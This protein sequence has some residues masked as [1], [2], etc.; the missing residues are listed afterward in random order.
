MHRS[1][2]TLLTLVAFA[3]APLETKAATVLQGAT[4]AYVAFEAEGNP[5]ITNGAPA[6]WITTNDATASGN[7]VLYIAG[8]TDNALAPHS[9][10]LYQI[11]FATAGT[12]HLYYRFK[13]D[14]ARTVADQFTGNS[15]LIPNLLG[16]FATAGATGLVDFHTAASNG[17]QAPANNVFDWQREADTAAYTV[18]A[19]EVAAGLP[20]VLSIG[21]R[22]AGFTVDRWILSPDPALTDA[23]L[24]ALENSETSVVVQGASDAYVAFEAET[25]AR[26]IAGTPAFW[27]TT[28]DVTASASGVLYIAGTTD[29]ALAPHSFALYQ[30]KFATA[31]TYHLYY[32]FKADAARTVADQFTGNSCLIPN[33][34]GTFTTAG[35]A[36]L[37]DFHTA[38]SNGG[39]APANN[40]FDWQREADTA[41]YTVSAA[42][43]AAGVPLVLTIATREAG[44]TVDR[45]VLSPDPA[46][47]D[48][49]LDALPNSGARVAAPSIDKAVG[50]A[51]L[52]TV[53]LSFTRPLAAASVLANRFTV[54]GGLAVTAAVLDVEDPRRVTLTTGAQTQGTVYTVTAVNVTDT[55]GTP[56]G[57]NTTKTFTAWKLVEGWATQ[58]I[59]LGATGSTVADLTGSAAYIAGTPSEIRWVK[60]F[61]LNNDPRGPNLGA[62]I[63]AF[64]TPPAAGIQNFYVFNDDEAELLLSSNQTEASLQSLNVFALSTAPVFDDAI[65]AA[66]PALTAGQRYLLVG[67]VKSGG[68]D[69]RLSVA[70]QP[71]GAGTPAANLSVLGGSRI[72]TFVNPDLGNVKFDQQPANATAA[73]GDRAR[74]SVKV[75]ATEGPVYYQWRVNGTD[76]P[77]ATRTTY[78]T[79][80]LTAADSGK[81]YSVV[82]SVAGKDTASANATLTVQGTTASNLQSYIGINFVGGGDNLPGPLTGVDV[83]GV[84]LQ[85]NWNNLTGTTFDQ[86]A[87]RDAAGA[88]TPITFTA[89]ATDHWY[90]GTLGAGDAN[91]VLLQG[92]LSA[93]ASLDPFALT[94]NNVPA[95]TYNLVVY[96]VGF[97]FQASYEESF[98]VTGATAS[99]TLHVKAE[100]GLE[101]NASPSFRRMTS[102]DANNRGA[103]GNYVQFDN[104]RPAADGSLTIT[105]AWESTNVGNGHQPAV[106]GIQLV[107]VGAAP[108]LPVSLSAALQGANLTISWPA[109]AAGFVLESS[110]AIGAGAAWTTVAGTPNPITVAG[111]TSVSVAAGTRFYRLKK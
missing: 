109:S 89:T 105:A 14:A 43:V 94:L 44:F 23:A 86:V 107:K 87:L 49:T 60:G 93:G 7:S 81:V 52:N 26:L 21:T 68:G 10:A 103:L 19:A 74:F 24:D 72:S 39:Q 92:Y 46:L 56:V 111:S 13:A 40:V 70:S 108:A 58:E 67:R 31:G 27:I 69:F 37:A 75:T 50:S 98:S 25:K 84:A 6:I 78:Y 41:A 11:K 15:C 45:W 63:S 32:R 33:V 22:E 104:V 1:I 102:T 97:P 62:E 29:N 20:L 18:T 54:S 71:A 64:F 88:N 79:P 80:V 57:A 76:I 9:F 3:A 61:Q 51:S 5:T 28:N 34:L 2:L 17:G 30:I 100:S 96:S 90:C 66:S 48:A 47:T 16:T 83:A 53:T 4:S 35:A 73:A 42:E 101:F 77:G 91:G 59:Y 99:P 38:A 12:Y 85:E 82:V 106:N 55:S 8:T 65:V 110:A 36:G 95:G